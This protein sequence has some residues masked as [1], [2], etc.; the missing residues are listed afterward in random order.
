MKKLLTTLLLW[1]PLSL[2]LAL[3]LQ[4]EEQSKKAQPAEQ[5]QNPDIKQ[6][7]TLAQSAIQQAL[8]VVQ[9]SG[10]VYPF[11][12]VYNKGSE[13]LQLVGYRGDPKTKPKAEDFTVALFLQVR[14]M[15]EGNTDIE[16]AVVLKPFYVTTDEGKEIP[17]I[18]ATVDHRN[19]K[20]WVMFQP[21][22][23]NEKKSG[24]YTLG[25]MIYQ[26]AQEGIFPS[27]AK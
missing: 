6:M 27:P 1:L 22:I 23:K 16:A 14:K 24:H 21:L 5:S 19:Q 13:E 11:A 7:E 4:A 8:K 20:P 2:L 3:P 10:G 17:G 12:L 25:E 26:Q 9:E 15:A 18:W